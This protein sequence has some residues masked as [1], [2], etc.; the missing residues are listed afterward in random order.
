M[1]A[2]LFSQHGPAEVLQIGDL[3]D[4]SPKTNEVLV[5]LEY[6][7][8][9]HVDIWV[10][11]GNPAYPVSLPHVLGADGA[12]MVMALGPEAEGISVG[13]RVLIIPALSCGLCSFCLRGLD[14][15]CDSFEILGARRHGTY[16]DCVLV[17]DQNVIPLP[18]EITTEIAAAFPLAYHT[19]WHMLISR[20]K[21][22]KGETVLI[23][24]SSAGVGIAAI[25]IAKWKGATVLAVTRQPNKKEKILKLGAD[26]VILTD[27]EPDFSGW[28]RRETKGLG[29]P[30]VFEHVGPATWPY[31]IQSLGRY[32]RLVTCGA[33]SGPRTELDLRYVFSRDLSVLGAKMGTR[34]EFVQL[35]DVIFS[36][37]IKPVIDR[38]FPLSEAVQAHRYMEEAHQIGK[39]LLTHN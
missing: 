10:R 1:K 21:L 22:E 26:K 25:Q 30:V 17:P 35:V 36:G 9:N 20:A 38:V 16:G 5:K 24:G 7:G 27:K 11:A 28:A 34:K 19:A 12:G 6:S 23:V 18:D 33:T 3:P 31:S 8:L 4:P 13:D 32:G 29:V 14:N 15:Q 39:I 2:I 37:K